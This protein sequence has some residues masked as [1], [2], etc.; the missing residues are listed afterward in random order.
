MREVEDSGSLL[1]EIQREIPHLIVVD[2][3]LPPLEGMELCQRIKKYG[4][5]PIMVLTAL[6]DDEL[7]I[8]AL[9][10]Y[11]EDYV[12][13]PAN[14]AEVIARV[15]RVLRRTWL[16]CLPMGLKIEVV[17]EHLGLDFLRRESRTP[18]GTIR[19]APKEWL[20]LQLLLR[21]AGHIV[22]NAVLL[23]R[24]WPDTPNAMGSLWEHVRRV[25]RKIGDDATRPRYIVSEPGLGYR[26]C[27]P[28][29]QGT[30]TDAQRFDEI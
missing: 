22:P 19:F 23:D 11:A 18:E 1:A 2:L 24:L 8:K 20:F 13:K 9:D 7:K 25:R 21:N 3:A 26:F 28:L 12:L 29:A 30:G 14:C 17:D 4:D 6:D 15:K 16:S 10:L 5:V 27:G